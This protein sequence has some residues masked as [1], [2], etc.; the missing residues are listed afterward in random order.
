L[1]GS[2]NGEERKDNADSGSHDEHLGQAV[3]RVFERD[4][5]EEALVTEGKQ[6]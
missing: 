2:E 4:V 1:N 6:W 5:Q 3:N